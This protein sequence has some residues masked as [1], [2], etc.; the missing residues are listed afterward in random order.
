MRNEQP[1][2]K[3][4]SKSYLYLKH[5][6]STILTC[7]GAVGVVVTAVT[8]ARASSKV[9][10]LLEKARED[11]G[12]DL[13][14]LETAQIAVP[15]YIPSAVIGAS[16]IACIFGANVLNK[17]QQAAITSAYALMERTYKEYRGKVK[18][19]FG[20]ETDIQIREAIAKEKR[21]E[22][23][24]AYVPGYNS[25]VQTDDKILFYDEYRKGYFE[26]S[27]DEVR[28]AEYHLNR[29]F[30]HRGY[31]ALNE[32]YEFLGL[33]PIECGD[34]LGWGCGR[35]IEEYESPWIDFN[36]RIVEMEDGMECCIIE[37]P[38]PPTDNFE[39]W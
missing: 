22:N 17:R 29:N 9:T 27:M 38:I 18:E 20:E 35:M 7:V 3:L 5:N 26:A 8:A 10:K 15:A 1:I 19:M 16:T 23:I 2:K 13:S 14:K 4:C 33:E 37:I 32:F 39:E 34:I 24:I 21:D 31:V 11:K 12:E 28:N 6:S 36:H 30:A 25:F